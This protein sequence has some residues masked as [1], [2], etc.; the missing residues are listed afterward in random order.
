MAPRYT[1]E[2][3]ASNLIKHIIYFA[4]NE[5]QK[6][7][8]RLHDNEE[9]NTDEKERKNYSITIHTLYKMYGELKVR[10]LK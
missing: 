4:L 6:R 5:W 1:G 8:E 3:W 10:Q 9:K 7:N 2:W